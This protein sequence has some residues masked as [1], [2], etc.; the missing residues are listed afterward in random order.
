MNLQSNF[1]EEIQYDPENPVDKHFNHFLEIYDNIIEEAKN[2]SGELLTN[3][4]IYFQPVF[5]QIM[6]LIQGCTDLAACNYNENASINDGSCWFPIVHHDCSGE[7][8]TDI[9][10]NGECGGLS[11]PGYECPNG[12]LVCTET[13]CEGLASNIK[14]TTANYSV[15]SIYPNP[16]NPIASINYTLP[17]NIHLKL[18]V[19]DVRGSQIA[20]LFNDFQNAGYHT[21]NWDASSYPSGL[22]FITMSAVNFN[23]T[24][25]IVFIK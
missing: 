12:N 25:K 5:Q 14:I 24:H 21:I 6:E 3:D 9:D 7:C 11:I 16:F 8:I 1:K 20:T 13:E 18:S 17:D 15:L 19:F 22:Y 2:M 23:Q 4:Y 10:C